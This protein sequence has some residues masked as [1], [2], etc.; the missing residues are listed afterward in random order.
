MLIRTHKAQ[1]TGTIVDLI[2]RG[3]DDGALAGDIDRW[4]IVCV[5]HGHWCSCPTRVVAFSW[6]PHPEDWCEACMAAKS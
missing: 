2:D 4:E 6:M 5:D 3:K 1:S